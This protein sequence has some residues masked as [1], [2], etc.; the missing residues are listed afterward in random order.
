[1]CDVFSNPNAIELIKDNQNKIDL[2]LLYTNPSIFIDEPRVYYLKNDNLIKYYN[3]Y[4]C[5]Q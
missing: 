3:S 2:Y 1:M 5:K 4:V